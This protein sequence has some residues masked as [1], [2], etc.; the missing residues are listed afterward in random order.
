MMLKKLICPDR[1]DVRRGMGY[2]TTAKPARAVTSKGSEIRKESK[3]WDMDLI[4]TWI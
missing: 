1:K 2:A 3:M 4:K